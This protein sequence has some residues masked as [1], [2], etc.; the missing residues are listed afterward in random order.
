MVCERPLWWRKTDEQGPSTTRGRCR[1]D[2][3]WEKR[4]AFWSGP[5]VD[6][7]VDSQS[8]SS[9]K[10]F[11]YLSSCRF[12]FVLWLCWVLFFFLNLYPNSYFYILSN[13]VF[14]KVHLPGDNRVPHLS[15]H[16]HPYHF[17]IN[18]FHFLFLPFVFKYF[19]ILPFSQFAKLLTFP[20]HLKF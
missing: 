13:Y 1:W 8:F 5:R 10:R 4:T 6:G 20:N 14:H 12:L 9:Q 17:P 3:G 16:F 11:C 19:I 15:S 2:M 18:I 7:R